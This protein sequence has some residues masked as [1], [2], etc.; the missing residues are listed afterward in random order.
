M[1]NRIIKMAWDSPTIMTWGN[2]FSGSIKLVVLTPLILVRYNVNEIAFWYLLLTINSFTVIVD[3][4]FYPTFSRLISYAFNG[5]ASVEEFGKNILSQKNTPNWILMQRIY[6]TINSIYLILGAGVII[7]VFGISYLSVSNIIG[8]NTNISYLWI[9]YWIYVLGEYFQFLSKKFDAVIIG[10]NNIVLIS[11]WNIIINVIN[12]FSAVLIVYYGGNLT[13]LAVNHFVFSVILC[14]RSAI[15]E[16][17]I[18]GKAFKSMKILGI[19]KEIFKWC[20][21]PTWKSGILVICSTGINQASGIIYAQTAD[22]SKLASYLLS[23]KLIST[24]SQFSQAPFYSKLPILSGLRVKNELVKLSELS[25]SAIKKALIVFVVGMG[26]L[27]FLGE[28]GLK[29]I[30]ANA[31]LIDPKILILMSFIWFLER[32]HAMHA[33]IYITTNKVPFYKSAIITGV[34]NIVLMWFLVPLFGLIAF[35]IAHGVSNLVINN[36]WNVALS[37]NSLHENFLGFFR[38]ST[39]IPLL[40][41]LLISGLKLLSLL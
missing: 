1:F 33:Q 40:M 17:E 27:I 25:A 32:H 7:I 10:T 24:I 6:S 38:R 13:I 14:L 26:G 34:V 23:L 29:L 11:R 41:L 16:R 22:P 39:I 9:A 30:G 8:N 28:F 20:W 4:G 3:F 2:F 21:G 35:P 18:C 5:L 36:W 19:D 12:A 37:L 15:L 31:K